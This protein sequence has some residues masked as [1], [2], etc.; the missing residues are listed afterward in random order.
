MGMYFAPD[1]AFTALT[2]KAIEYYD[3]HRFKGLR[4]CDIVAGPHGND[5]VQGWKSIPQDGPPVDSI[6][7]IGVLAGYVNRGLD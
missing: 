3:E 7:L 4:W 5:Y 1:S 6:S 2:Q